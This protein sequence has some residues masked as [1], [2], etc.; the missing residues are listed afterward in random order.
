MKACS[1]MRRSISTKHRF[2]LIFLFMAAFTAV[3]FWKEMQVNAQHVSFD[4]GKNKLECNDTSKVYNV[5]GSTE[6]NHIKIKGGTAQR[7][8]IVNLKDGLN[9]DLRNKSA[10]P[11]EV[12]KNSYAKIYIGKGDSNAKINL[13]GGHKSGIGK[14]WGY[15]GISCH[16]KSHVLISGDGTLNVYGGGE[17]YGGAGIGGNYNDNVRNLTIDGNMSINATGAHSAPGIGS[18][19]DGI[20]YDLTINNGNITARGGENAPGI[21]A[22]EA[23][24]ESGGDLHNLTINGGNIQAYGGKDAAGIGCSDGGDLKG[25]IAINGG[26]IEAR[27]GKYAAGIGGGNGGNITKK[28]KINIQCKQDKPMEIVARGGT[29][30]AGIGGGKDQSSCEIVIKGHP[31]KRELLKIRAFASS[32]GNRINDA[33]AIGSGQDDAGNITIKDATVYADAPYAGADIGSGSLKGRP[34]K[35]HSITIDN[36]T[37]AARGSNKIAAGIGAGHGGSI[38][39]IK[40][41]NSTYKGNSIGTSIYSSPAFNYRAHRINDMKEITIENSKIECDHDMISTDDRDA[42]TSGVA[43]IGTGPFGNIDLIQIKKSTVLA[44]GHGTG[45]G[46]G[47]GGWAPTRLLHKTHGGNAKKIIIE[48]SDVT[49]FAGKRGGG[50]GIGTGL[51]CDVNEIAITKSNIIAKAPANGEEGGAG[52]GSGRAGSVGTIKITNCPSVEA[53]GGPHSAGIGCGGHHT[54]VT[55]ILTTKC[56]PIVLTANNPDYKVKAFGGNKAAGIGTGLGGKFKGKTKDGNSIV[57]DG[58]SVD[59]SGGYGGAGIG[60]GA[61]GSGGRGADSNSILIKG[62]GVINA[63]GGEGAAGIGGGLGGSSNKIVID[64]EGDRYKNKGILRARG[65]LGAAG[66]GSGSVIYTDR[67]LFTPV[68]NSAGTVKIAGG[69][70]E[71]FGGNNRRSEKKDWRVYLGSGAGIGGGSGHGTLSKFYVTGGYISAHAGNSDATDIGHGGDL[72]GIDKRLKKDGKIEISGGT[73]LSNKISNE[74]DIIIDG[75]S[76]SANILRAKNSIKEN[77]YRATLTLADPP[78]RSVEIFPHNQSKA[79][80]TKDIYPDKKGK[81]YLY[82]PV[83]KPMKTTV[84]VDRN[85]EK[86]YHGT[87]TSDGNGLLK[88]YGEKNFKKPENEPYVGEDFTLSV[89]KGN[90]TLKD[91]NFKVVDGTD[92]VEIIESDSQNASVKLKAKAIGKFK[93]SVEMKADPANE[94]YWGYNASYSGSVSRQKGKISFTENPSKVY[95]GEKVK[96]PKVTTNS[97]GKV[98]YKYSTRDGKPLDDAPVNVG[99]Y[100]VTATV[101]GTKYYSEATASLDFSIEPASTNTSLSA[102]QDG[103]KATIK[104]VVSGLYEKNGKVRF[105]VNNNTDTAKEIPVSFNK[106]SGLY[107]A[108]L[109]ADTVSSGEY[110]ITAEFIPENNNYLSSKT[111]ATYNKDKVD[112]SISCKPLHEANYKDSGFKIEPTI[113]GGAS[114]S[115]DVWKYEIIKD[116]FTDYGFPSTVTIDSSGNVKVNNAGVAVVKITLIDKSGVYNN[117]ETYTT[118]KVKRAPL[119]VS[120][121]AYDKD[122]KEIT[123]TSYGSISDLNFG[124]KYDGFVRNDDQ[125]NFTRGHGSLVAKRLSDTIE[126][127]KYNIQ[128]NRKGTP[129]H[130]DKLHF[131][132]LFAS[133]NYKIEQKLGTLNVNPR[134]ITVKADDVSG[135]YGV[136]PKYTYSIEGL[137][138]FD[139]TEKAIDAGSKVSLDTE[140]AG[141]TYAQ[142]APG[143]YE[144]VLIPPD[145]AMK[146]YKIVKSQ[147]G[148]L[149]IESADFNDISRFKVTNP[150]FTTYNGKEQKQKVT[151]TDLHSKSSNGGG[152]N[153]GVELKENVDYELEYIGDLKNV[154]QVKV[155]VKGIGKYKGKV[156]RFYLIKKAPLVINTPDAEKVYDGKPLTASGTLKGLMPGE[157]AEIVMS[158]SQTEVGS[159]KNTAGVNWNGT[160][161]SQNYEIEESFGTLTVHK[162]EPPATP[163][164]PGKDDNPKNPDNGPRTPDNSSKDPG[165]SSKGPG[166]SPQNNKIAKTGDM[167]RVAGYTI[168]MLI[169]VIIFAAVLMVRKKTSK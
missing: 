160:A 82:F 59:A 146:N 168:D 13:Y 46:I 53:V 127:G 85:G 72:Y 58:Y 69:F 51:N 18:G 74:A 61:N 20:L 57:I 15:A 111:S 114:T 99:K 17:K 41:S 108:E 63:N 70:V 52:I 31:R 30:S 25:T 113:K 122:G 73:V 156:E 124:L 3:F 48:E 136:E 22:G 143:K 106:N 9:I 133:R 35:I 104:A 139:G 144:H 128:I 91:C 129:L 27:G 45:P 8:I 14:N 19:R 77:V 50:A 109:K 10:A 92:A 96:N 79:Y 93:I 47:G 119:K 2:F 118:I 161:N 83:S 164:D 135:I 62:K 89:D 56:G 16:E 112:R 95:D 36:S 100:K 163:D 155:V 148:N 87:V 39:R 107:E 55:T 110:K 60:G 88:M 117:A 153:D 28:G 130:T 23:I 145:K 157:T 6:K 64:M 120:S 67:T 78:N 84:G 76:V 5:Y 86:L 71:A 158:G 98:T 125:N 138:S 149:N 66:I 165:D 102:K 40:I 162:K 21:G 169:A 81:I 54:L 29:N 49:A 101:E 134:G 90:D 43:G 12:T 137:A 24:G 154:G 94:V 121:Y 68:G 167:S 116:K 150:E 159:S 166:N 147:A 11:I 141:G 105:V 132:N 142:L 7:P 140:K 131:N 38:D 44:K 151:V 65:G 4:I 26:N 152:T 97:D 80:G 75:G 33:A 103:S 126:V 123:E 34:G 1:S 32:A 37:I 42:I 115:K